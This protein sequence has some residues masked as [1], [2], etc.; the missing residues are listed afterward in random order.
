MYNFTEVLRAHF[1]DANTIADLAVA[2]LRARRYARTYPNA[3]FAIVLRKSGVV[4]VE[5]V[6]ARRWSGYRGH[7]LYVA[8]VHG[9]NSQRV[10]I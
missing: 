6:A 8:V 9:A 4:R 10:A 2:T 7:G 5:C 3:S 1:A